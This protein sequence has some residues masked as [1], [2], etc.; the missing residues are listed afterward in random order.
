MLFAFPWKWLL[1]FSIDIPTTVVIHRILPTNSIFFCIS[2][3]VFVLQLP[4]LNV[5]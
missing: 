4:L 2:L 3:L 1:I 5:D